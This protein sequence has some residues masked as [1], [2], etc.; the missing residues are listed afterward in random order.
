MNLVKP[1]VED[2]YEVRAFILK[3]DRLREELVNRNCEITEGDLRDE[4]SIESAVKGC[5]VVIHMGAVMKKPHNMTENTYWNINAT[6]TFSMVRTAIRAKTKRFIFASTDATYSPLNYNY[7]P[8]DEKHP[9]QAFSLYGVTKIVCENIVKGA[10][11]EAGLPISIVRYGTVRAGDEVLMGWHARNLMNTL[12]KTATHPSSSVYV[13]NVKEPWKL[14]ESIMNSED[15][16]VIPRGPDFRSWRKHISDVRDSVQG[17]ML[18]L[19]NDRA[20]GE[21]FN[22]LGPSSVTWEQAVKYIAEKTGQSY[23]ECKL[24]NYCEWEIST[25]KARRI[26]GYKPKYDIYKMIDSALDYRNGK[27]IG[28]FCPTLGYGFATYNPLDQ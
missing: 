19:E 7:L 4:E 21:D 8:I 14:L 25:E 27:D 2:G 18:V 13:E 3:N 20:I 11:K 17:T 22:I 26:L 1:L 6:G 28:V 23:I 16:L 10:W 5:D 24:D 9:Q 15:Q 12:K